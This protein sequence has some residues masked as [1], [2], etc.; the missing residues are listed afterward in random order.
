MICVAKNLAAER[1]ILS[2]P[3]SRSGKT[4]DTFIVKKVLDLYT[5]D[6]VSRIMAGKKNFISVKEDSDKVQKQKR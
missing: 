6:D 4:L 3:E 1:G 2:T 5:N